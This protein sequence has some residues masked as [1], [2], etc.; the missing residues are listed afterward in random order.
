MSD[1]A[2]SGQ[3]RTTNDYYLPR[4]PTGAALRD[5][6]DVRGR[7]RAERIRLGLT[8]TEAAR[9][10]GTTRQNYNCLERVIRDPRMSRILE[11]VDKLG[12]DPRAL[13]PELFRRHP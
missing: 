6:P 2:Y 8:S 10:L 7:I 1:G 4:R 5:V 12:M 9:R 11:L 3:V 13:V